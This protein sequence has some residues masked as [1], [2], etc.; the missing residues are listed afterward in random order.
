[1]LQI[2]KRLCESAGVV[3]VADVWGDVGPYMTEYRVIFERIEEDGDEI[4]YVGAVG[5]H[6]CV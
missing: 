3:C 2:L 6:D 5:F 1:M 4:G